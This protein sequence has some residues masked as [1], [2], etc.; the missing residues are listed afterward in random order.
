[1]ASA[2]QAWPAWAEIQ[3][4]S[5]CEYRSIGLSTDKSFGAAYR[6]LIAQYSGFHDQVLDAQEDGTY[7]PT[8]AAAMKEA[9]PG[10]FESGG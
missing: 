9:C 2:A 4:Q 10:A 7:G 5:F 6:D 8:S 1:M 3:A